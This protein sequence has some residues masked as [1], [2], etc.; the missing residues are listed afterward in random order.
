MTS[1]NTGSGGGN[2]PIA[3]TASQLADEAGRTAEQQAS[4]GMDRAAE[5][6]DQVVQAVRQAT[7]QLRE[8][9][10]QVA[11][12][13][14]MAVQQVEKSSQ[15][16]RQHEPREIVSGIESW[17]RRQPALALGGSLA[18]GLLAGRFLRSSTPPGGS[19]GGARFADGYGYGSSGYGDG[20]RYG[21]GYGGDASGYGAGTGTLGAAGLG[22]TGTAYGD[23]SGVG[24]AGLD[25]TMIDRGDEFVGDEIDVVPDSALDDGIDVAATSTSRVTS[26]TEAR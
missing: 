9:Q 12:F 2:E 20:S 25:E 17:A 19:S 21:G 3:R 5:T 15:Y 14:D 26:D 23:D 6:L 16:L 4:R 13:A 7:D 8:Q 10:P 18:L 24:S 22:A 1:Q 11:S